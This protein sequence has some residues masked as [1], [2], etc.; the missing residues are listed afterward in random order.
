VKIDI[1]ILAYFL[2][3]LLISS[4]LLYQKSYYVW[5]ANKCEELF[6]KN[7]ESSEIT[8][9][10]HNSTFNLKDKSKVNL[11]IMTEDSKI[12]KSEFDALVKTYHEIIEILD[13][14]IP[15][16]SSLTIRLSY[17]NATGLDAI[18]KPVAYLPET[19]IV[20]IPHWYIEI[21][22][23]NAIVKKNRPEDSKAI[24]IHEIAH[25]ILD[26]YLKSQSSFWKVYSSEVV[27][28]RNNRIK[29]S[30]L[31][32]KSFEIRERGLSDLHKSQYA[33]L[34]NQIRSDISK[35]GRLDLEFKMM[36]LYDP[37]N[38]EGL[39][40]KEQDLNSSR[41]ELDMKWNSLYDFLKENLSTDLYNEF[42][43]LKKEA[44]SLSKF[45]YEIEESINKRRELVIVYDEFWAD[46]MSVVVLKDPQAIPRAIDFDNPDNPN[47]ER[48]FLRKILPDNLSSE[49]IE[50]RPIVIEG[51]AD[52]PFGDN[53]YKTYHHPEWSL[54]VKQ[55]TY[56]DLEAVKYHL[57][58]NYLSKV[59]T[60]EELKKILAVVVKT[61]EEEI[62]FRSNNQ[63]ISLRELNTRFIKRVD[64]L[65]LKLSV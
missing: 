38:K 56:S 22:S 58:T 17:H 7:K 44:G 36:K 60:T 3:K 26:S 57:W 54:A 37:L 55:K 10:I 24:Q 62:D 52:D 50:N 53:Y 27:T 46:L 47:A 15:I 48:S 33:E 31:N 23:N 14:V 16:P 30:E 65:M 41:N 2:I 45:Q 6:L 42:I 8:L 5:G 21:K 12:T 1:K 11:R 20:S 59:K 28:N 35:V 51:R 49:I 4:V 25:A 64:D 43:K 18:F 13:G 9:N 61:I 29:I 40:L 32:K 39:A 19:G 34:Y 63:S